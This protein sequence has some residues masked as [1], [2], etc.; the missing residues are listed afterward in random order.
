MRKVTAGTLAPHTRM[1]EL[2]RRAVM[3]EDGRRK[4]HTIVEG[5]PVDVIFAALF[6]GPARGR[7]TAP[8][9]IEK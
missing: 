5:R 6:R 1:L 9:P 3:A 4:D 8:M 7:C 2:L